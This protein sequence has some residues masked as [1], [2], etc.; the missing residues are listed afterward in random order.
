MTYKFTVPPTHD[1]GSYSGTCT[2]SARE[3]YRQNALR[4]YNSV[5]AHDGHPPVFKMPDGTTYTRVYEWEVDQWYP[6]R[7]ER[8]HTATTRA[9]AAQVMKVYRA[10]TPM[11]LVRT[12]R[13]PA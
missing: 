10:N 4:D 1:V 12:R 6:G 11:I 9:E 3:T 7:W 13:V 2:A 5:R 8:V